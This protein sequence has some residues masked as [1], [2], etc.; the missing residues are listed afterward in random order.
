MKKLINVFKFEFSSVVAKKSWVISTVILI[1][2]ILAISFIPRITNEFKGGKTTDVSKDKNYKYGVYIE[3]GYKEQ[4]FSD[5]F[6][7]YKDKDKLK[8]D[9]LNKSLTTGF[10]LEGENSFISI[11]KDLEMNSSKHE[12]IFKSYL[13]N[14]KMSTFLNKSNINPIEFEK[15]NNYNPNSSKI[16]LGKNQMGGYILAYASIF[17]LYM[18]VIFYGQIVSTSV[19]KEKSSRTT[20]ILITSVNT[21]TLIF[22]KVLGSGF[23]GIFQFS[24]I[25]IAGYIAYIINKDTLPFNI[26]GIF[27]IPLI[28]LFIAILFLITGYFLFVTLFAAVASLVSKIEDLSSAITPIILIIIA[29]FIPTMSSL[30]FPDSNMMRFL[31]FF[32]F[33]SPFAA[34]GRIFMSSNFT[35]IQISISFAIL[36]LTFLFGVYISAK[37]YRFGSLYYGNK[38][39]LFK[40]IKKNKEL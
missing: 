39:S 7:I 10:I 36:L 29:A 23:A 37:I 15:V 24:T 27:N 6:V 34:V 30:A 33:T 25:A 3:D 21:N 26:E 1:L 8:K 9:V 12:N 40:V 20:E 14:K 2:I 17:I 35:F 38:I 11:H 28:N 22:G 16:V 19:A 32:P 31:S 5:N 13:K 4:D 18:S